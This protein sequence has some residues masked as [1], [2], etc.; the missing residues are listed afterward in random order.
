M[1]EVPTKTIG[2]IVKY[3]ILSIE[4]INWENATFSIGNYVKTK[5]WNDS[6]SCETIRGTITCIYEMYVESEGINIVVELD[7]L[8]DHPICLAHIKHS[9]LGLKPRKLSEF[10]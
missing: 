9:E 1:S 5:L 2:N 7:K 10:L 8:P 3:K 4:R 6:G